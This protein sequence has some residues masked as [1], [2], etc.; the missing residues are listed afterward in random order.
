VIEQMEGRQYLSSV[1]ASSTA[2]VGDTTTFLLN[3]AGSSAPTA[4]NVNFGDGSSA[5]LAGMATSTTHQF[6]TAGSFAPTVTITDANGTH[7]PLALGL[8]PSFASN[9]TKLENSSLQW[10][11]AHAALI[12]YV[13]GTPPKLLVG[14]W[15]YS[16]AANSLMFTVARYNLDGTIDTSFGDSD[17]NGGH[18]GYSITG[19]GSTWSVAANMILDPQGNIVLVGGNNLDGLILVS[20]LTANGA[21]DPSFGSNGILQTRIG[22]GGGATGVVAASDGSLYVNGTNYIN[23]TAYFTVFRVTASGTIDTT[24]GNNGG[25][26]QPVFAGYWENSTAML[27]DPSNNTLLVGGWVLHGE[28][29]DGWNFAITRIHATDGSTD[30][31]FGSDGYVLTDFDCRDDGTNAIALQPDGKILAAG[32]TSSWQPGPGNTYHFAIA[33]YN[34]DGS[35]DVTFGGDR[36]NPGCVTLK[37]GDPAQDSIA[38]AIV[39]QP[40]GRILVGGSSY[41]DNGIQ[42]FTLARL[43]PADGSLDGTYGVN[44]VLTTGLAGHSTLYGLALNPTT[45]GAFAAGLM[46][47]GEID[48]SQRHWLVASYLSSNRVTVTGSLAAPTNLAAASDGAN[49]VSLTW[50]GSA[51]A[52]Y[53]VY[54]S[55]ASG[56][57][58]QV[59]APIA[60]GLTAASYHDTTTD[61]GTTYYYR[62]V[63]TSANGSDVSSPSDLAS[64]TT[65]GLAHDKL[66][67]GGFESPRIGYSR[68]ASTVPNSHWALA[69]GASYIA[70]NSYLGNPSSPQGT[71]AIALENAA[72]IRQT[73]NFSGGMYAIAYTAAQRRWGANGEHVTN[74]NLQILIDGAKADIPDK[75]PGSTA[76]APDVTAAFYVPAGTHTITI[77]GA[78]SAGG[79]NCAFLDDVRLLRVPTVTA[80]PITAIASAEFDGIVATVIPVSPEAAETDYAP[81][82]AWGDGTTSQGEAFD[83]ADGTLSV[84]ASHTFAAAGSYTPHVSV[85]HVPSGLTSS[86]DGS[87]TV[88]E[89]PPPVTPTAPDKATGLT[90]TAVSTTSIGLVWDH[91]PAAGSYT[92]TRTGGAT[93]PQTFTISD[94]S[95]NSFVDTGLKAHTQYSYTLTATNPVGT[96]PASDAVSAATL[97]SVPIAADSYLSTTHAQPL[98][99]P[100]APPSG[101]FGLV[102]YATDAD[103]YETLSL[104]ESSLSTPQHGTLSFVDDPQ[105]GRCVRY[106]PA[107]GYLGPD[108]FTFTVTDGFDHSRKGT[109]SINVT[110]TPP[111]AVSLI[112]GVSYDT[113]GDPPWTATGHAYLAGG[114]TDYDPAAHFVLVD[115]P[116]N[117]S[118]VDAQTGEISITATSDAQG[119]FPPVEV[120]YRIN[121][122]ITDG[123]LANA[124]FDFPGDFYPYRSDPVYGVTGTTQMVQ[125][126]TAQLDPLDPTGATV[127]IVEAPK[128]GTLTPGPGG[129]YAYTPNIAFT[130]TD[131]VTYKFPDSGSTDPGVPDDPRLNTMF[132]QVDPAAVAI[133]AHR[134][135]LNW[136]QTVSLDARTSGDPDKYVIL[137]NDAHTEHHSDGSPD[138]A[139]T[140]ATVPTNWWRSDGPT[141]DVV[142]EPDLA[143]IDLSAVGA[144]SGTLELQLSDPTAV[145]LLTSNWYTTTDQHFATAH[146]AYAPGQGEEQNLTMDLADPGANPHSVFAGQLWLEGLKACHDSTM[147]MIYRDG[148]GQEVARDTL[149]MDIAQFTFTGDSGQ[150]ITEAERF[151]ELALQQLADGKITGLQAPP[152]TF[153]VNLDGVGFSALEGLQVN[154]GSNAADRYAASLTGTGSEATTTRPLSLYFSD[155]SNNLLTGAQRAAIRGDLS[156]DTLHNDGATVTATTQAGDKFQ[157]E[158]LAGQ[159]TK[160]DWTALALARADIDPNQWRPENGFVRLT[161]TDL[162]QWR[163][164][165]KVYAYYQYVYKQNNNLHWAGMAVLAG[166]SVWRG[167]Q[168]VNESRFDIAVAGGLLQ[169]GHLFAGRAADWA[170][171]GAT[172][173]KL[174]ETTMLQMQKDIFMDLAW[175]HEAYLDGGIDALKARHDAKEIDD[176]TYE[177]WTQIDNGIKQNDQV[178]IWTG[179]T[180]LLQREQQTIL[181]DGYAR[182]ASTPGVPSKMSQQIENAF[183]GGPFTGTDVTDFNQRWDWIVNQMV[184]PWRQLTQAQRDSQ[185]GQNL[186]TTFYGP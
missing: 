148:R 51:G 169:A 133:T 62:V 99:I 36:Q 134:T 29:L 64:F 138:N 54:R 94:P 92:V 95:A 112:G 35:P 7:A 77:L 85:T 163:I 154:S 160:K 111:T 78:N 98:D 153:H 73:A 121:D 147:T 26:V 27:L 110:N 2:N 166:R 109:V 32:Q 41:D 60:V 81:L 139:D 185:V 12:Q 177:A 156:I 93:G 137:T 8:D 76:Y 172:V 57:G 164:V 141:F 74:Q 15:S 170:E 159:L 146:E 50:S 106:T 174:V 131:W 49:G 16:S 70:N 100:I 184:A 44:G 171:L 113:T 14:G 152:S 108:S 125:G 5:T 96:S 19:L 68:T 129:T 40:D 1:A 53:S 142:P 52:T 140:T 75:T 24:W 150:T 42:S 119:T 33:R 102:S 48:N 127:Q 145:R 186:R 173:S 158:I 72:S 130:G 122:G 22:G 136:G 83:N 43:N 21:A 116:A 86:G 87:A 162:S 120:F 180:R 55:T 118:L 38:N 4:I 13:N 123:N 155:S 101:G 128:H 114:D 104:D 168:T 31:S 115:P 124:R 103:P 37:V 161:D 89:P 23:G 20:R 59:A 143:K 71:Q 157:R 183:G 69:N 105:L 80:L 58:T 67:D 178:L 97:N 18:T 165:A 28:G 34:P 9:G 167:L 82:I 45:G 117:V 175:Q 144:T 149:H 63:A 182:L 56:F 39:V 17:G 30:T 84:W 126:D 3:T 25:Y 47:D 46:W 132:F 79:Y 151:P 6:A 90:A 107:A 65:P 181:A 61:T 88:T 66:L 10:G 11:E 179:N 135:G 91:I 176:D